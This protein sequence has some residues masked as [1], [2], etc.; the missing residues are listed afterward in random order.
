M[1]TFANGN[2][3]DGDLAHAQGDQ[4]ELTVMPGAAGTVVRVL[5]YLNHARM[6][7]YA[8]AMRVAQQ[9]GQAPNIVADDRPGRAKYG[10]GL[11]VEQPLADAGETG[12]FARLGWSDGR[13]ESFAFTEVDR[14]ASAGVQLSGVRWG[15][16][17][18]V[19]GL[20]AS[21]TTR[22][23]RCTRSISRWVGTASCWATGS[24]TTATSGSSRG[25]TA[26]SSAASCR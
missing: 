22:S 11:N 16:R 23:H 1:P 9:T 7:S 15:R 14:H 25:T 18:D 6:G 21:W 20:G 3:L 17:S 10:F 12:L 8:D 4:V 26:S 24:S 5:G 13:N 2:V 19:V